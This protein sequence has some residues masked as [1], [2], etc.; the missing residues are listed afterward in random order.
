MLEKRIFPIT[1]IETTVFEQYWPLA[2]ILEKSRW[3]AC[4]TF[5]N[6]QKNLHLAF[7]DQMAPQNKKALGSDN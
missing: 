6:F 1:S 7:W 4:S 3:R 2:A 5:S